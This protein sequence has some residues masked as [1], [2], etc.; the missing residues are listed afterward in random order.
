MSIFVI[1][2]VLG[3]G[4]GGW[5]FFQLNHRTGDANSGSNVVGA[6]VAALIVFLIVFTLL[7][8]VLHL[9]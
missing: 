6:A 2:L 4:A 9:H 8:Y 3:L 1:A 7:K 5:L